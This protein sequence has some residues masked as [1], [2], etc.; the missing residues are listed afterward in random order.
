VLMDLS[1][2]YLLLEDVSDDRRFKTWYAKTGSPYKS[3][4]VVIFVDF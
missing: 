3:M 2:G 1:T 4:Q